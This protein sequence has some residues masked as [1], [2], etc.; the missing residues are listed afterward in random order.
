MREEEVGKVEKE[1][2]R[3]KQDHRGSI[4]LLQDTKYHTYRYVRHKKDRRRK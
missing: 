1:K 4:K 2:H 3:N